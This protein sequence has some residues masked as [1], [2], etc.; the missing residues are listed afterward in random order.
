[1]CN[2]ARK[3]FFSLDLALVPKLLLTA[4]SSLAFS[5]LFPLP[6]ATEIR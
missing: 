1:M 2:V 5:S 4:A 3:F 6:S